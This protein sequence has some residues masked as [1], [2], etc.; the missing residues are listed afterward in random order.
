MGPNEFP[1]TYARIVGEP[2]DTWDTLEVTDAAG[3]TEPSVD[4]YR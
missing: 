2:S 3:L 1:S 4:Q